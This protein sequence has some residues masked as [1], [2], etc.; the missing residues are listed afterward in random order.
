M[1]TLAVVGVLICI[2]YL[3]TESEEPVHQR[4]KP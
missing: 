1:M 4:K 3:S 2:T